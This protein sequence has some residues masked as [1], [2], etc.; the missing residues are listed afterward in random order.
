MARSKEAEVSKRVRKE[1]VLGESWS[2]ANYR[3]NR[4]LLHHMVQRMGI[5]CYHCGGHMPRDDFSIEHKINWL[6]HP[7]GK[8]LFFD[9]DNVTFSHTACNREMSSLQH[10]HSKIPHN[11]KHIREKTHAN[12]GPDHDICNEQ[13]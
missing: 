5:R 7:D 10:N 13:G 1:R 4:D 12:E 2:T 9:P 11:I 8:R 6:N 3:L